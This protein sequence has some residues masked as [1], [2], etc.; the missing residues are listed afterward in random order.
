MTRLVYNSLCENDALSMLDDKTRTM[1]RTMTMMA[2]LMVQDDDYAGNEAGGGDDGDHY[3][4]D[5]I[6]DIATVAD[7]NATENDEDHDD[8]NELDEY[9]DD[10]DDDGASPCL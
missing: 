8:H 3:D 6:D 5:N 1:L 7:D 9:D 4:G 2:M 10:S